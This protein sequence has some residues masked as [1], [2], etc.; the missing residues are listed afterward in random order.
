MTPV[1]ALYPLLLAPALKVKVWGGRKLAAHLNKALPTADPYGEAW[2]LHDTATITNGAL[3]GHTVAAAVRLWGTALIGDGFDPAAGMPLLVKYLDATDWLSV[4]VHPDDVQA[5]AL[6]GEPRGKTE[7][8]YILAAD[9]GARLVCGVTPHVSADD[10]RAAIAAGQLA[11]HLVYAEVQPG[12]VLLN[13]AGAIHA[14]GPGILI[15]EIQQSSDTTYRLY[16]WDRPDLNGQP[17]PLH[18]DKSLTVM[19]TARPPLL[20]HTGGDPSPAVEL[21]ECPYFRTTL[22]QLVPGKHAVLLPT[23]GAFQ[24]L[25][26]I[27]GDAV[28]TAGGETLRLALGE[29][30]L[31]PAGLASCTLAAGQ[32]PARVLRS[33]AG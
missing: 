31:I 12:D 11:D 32:L 27:A 18:I 30:A 21:V 7:A 23:G 10:L 9:A 29:T 24:T 2:E 8:W 19:N 1:P 14:L 26:C 15:Y 13:L 17:R 4:Q 6:E 3:A 20:T 33:W 25:S 16:D 28:I 22:H 5:A